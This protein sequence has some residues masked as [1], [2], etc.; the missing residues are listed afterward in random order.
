VQ[1][2]PDIVAAVCL[3]AALLVALQARLCSMVA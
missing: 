3:V 2:R 1:R